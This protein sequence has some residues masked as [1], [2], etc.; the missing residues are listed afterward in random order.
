M[1]LE[2]T[3][4]EKQSLQRIIPSRKFGN[5]RFVAEG[6]KLDVELNN[7]WQWSSSDILNNTLRGTLAEYIIAL[8]LGIADGIQ[9]GW[10]SYDLDYQGLKIEVKSSAYIQSWAQKDYSKI[11]FNVSM[12]KAFDPVTGGLAELSI[13]QAD[14]YAFCV[15]TEKDAERI[16]PLDMDQWTFYLVKTHDLDAAIGKRKTVTLSNIKQIEH[17]PCAYSEIKQNIDH[18]IEQNTF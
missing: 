15:L 18:F 8:A 4:V 2:K 17:V 13:R 12:T 3:V 9:E 7:F 11:I 10:K 14:I 1:N 6:Q 5:E 16:N